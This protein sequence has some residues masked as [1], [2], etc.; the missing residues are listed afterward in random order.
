MYYIDNI[1]NTRHLP[2]VCGLVTTIA[3]SLYLVHILG[4]QIS[5]ATPTT[6]KPEE[7]RSNNNSKS[8]MTTAIA[9]E[10]TGLN[11]SSTT[12]AGS[13][14][15]TLGDPFVEQKGR[16]T[17][18]RVLGVSNNLARIE[19]SFAANDT[20][21]GNITAKD[22]GTY[23]TVPRPNSGGAGSSTYKVIYGEGQGMIT[24]R[25]GDTATWTGQGIGQIT[26]DGRIMFHGSVIF[27]TT[28]TGKL[29]FLNNMV[30]M[31]RHE[32]DSLGN[33]STKVW[34]WK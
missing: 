18:Q 15:M 20:I 29:A 10:L 21:N 17:G 26:P 11:K 13:T 32:A 34:G 3:L 19:T 5:Y 4:Q 28:S 7:V 9:S 8:T 31:F 33:I 23:V 22:I 12:L 6:A 25:D 30:G 1:K 27:S 2:L 24:T 14:K 16:I